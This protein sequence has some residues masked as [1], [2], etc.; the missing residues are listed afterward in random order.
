MTLGWLFFKL[1][2]FQQAVLYLK[3]ILHSDTHA[4]GKTSTIL[5]TG[6]GCAVLVYH[7][8]H[9]WKENLPKAVDSMCYGTMLFMIILNAG[10]RTPFIYFQF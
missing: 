8:A 6:Y 1:Q 9:V 5:I 7:L 4:I 2:D 3:T 10:P